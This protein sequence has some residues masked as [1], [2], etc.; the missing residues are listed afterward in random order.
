MNIPDDI[1]CYDDNQ[2]L[3]VILVEQL[4]LGTCGSHYHQVNNNVKI[5][6]VD[7]LLIEQNI[8][9]SLSTTKCK[10]EAQCTS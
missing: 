6:T 3:R 5:Y 2:S 1:H 7:N 4:F 10:H 9:S 8:L